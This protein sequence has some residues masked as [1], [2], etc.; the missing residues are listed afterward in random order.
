MESSHVG[1]LSP[2]TSLFT[3]L[4]LN[5]RKISMI[6]GLKVTVLG[7]ELKGICMARADFHMKRATFHEKQKEVL[8]EEGLEDSM[9]N[10]QNAPKFA[11]IKDHRASA[12]ELIFIANHLKLEEE[13]LLDRSDLHKL[14]ISNGGY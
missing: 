2:A 11:R 5:D 13:Y 8:E 6:E 10:I 7:S 1:E 4:W 14:G 12:D 9:S 3:I